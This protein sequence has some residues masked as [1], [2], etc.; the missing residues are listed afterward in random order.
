VQQLIS[1][2]VGRDGEGQFGPCHRDGELV[3]T[4]FDEQNPQ[5]SGTML[6]THVVEILV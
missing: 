1:L 6:A 3:D 4:C 2:L 5:M